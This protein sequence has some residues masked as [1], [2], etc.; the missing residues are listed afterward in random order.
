MVELGCGNFK[1]WKRVALINGEV[2]AGIAGMGIGRGV[3]GSN[4][5]KGIE[6]NGGVGRRVI[7]GGRIMGIII[8]FVWVVV[9]IM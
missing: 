1:G 6:V 3:K 7:M 5:V 2:N 8:G 9:L 4:G